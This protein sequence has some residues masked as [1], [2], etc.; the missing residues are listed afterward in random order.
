MSMAAT[1]KSLARKHKSR[2]WVEATKK[3]RTGSAALAWRNRPLAGSGGSRMAYM[4][5]HPLVKDITSELAN[6]SA[7]KQG[8]LPT[9]PANMAG[10]FR[11][12]KAARSPNGI[13]N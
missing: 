11:E 5:E 10:Y 2:T 1:N 9:I 13:C 3:R 4:P 12:K 7:P 8:K 6:Y